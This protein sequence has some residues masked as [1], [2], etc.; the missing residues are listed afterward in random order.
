MM[1]NKAECGFS[2]GDFPAPIKKSA[3][4]TG[5]QFLSQGDKGGSKVFWNLSVK[6]VARALAGWIIHKAILCLL[7]KAQGKKHTVCAGA[8]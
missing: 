2:G 5:C 8:G 6:A 7:R 4:M 1:Q 3:D